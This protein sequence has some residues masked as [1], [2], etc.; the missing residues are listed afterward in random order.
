MIKKEP[1][2]QSLGGADT[3]ISLIY[4]IYFQHEVVIGLNPAS[5]LLAA[6]DNSQVLRA[7]VQFSQRSL[8]EQASCVTESISGPVA[9]L[10]SNMHS[11]P[12]SRPLR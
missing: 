3:R 2:I 4:Y 6:A 1:N 5:A 9:T 11:R 8:H 12:L 7:Q 10:C